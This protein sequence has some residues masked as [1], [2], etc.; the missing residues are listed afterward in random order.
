MGR[1]TLFWMTAA[2]VFLTPAIAF[3]DC[4]SEIQDIDQTIASIEL[5]DGDKEKAMDLRNT[6]EKQCQV[7]NEREAEAVIAQVREILEQ[8]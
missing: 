7:G 4:K 1:E 3:A 2:A 5:S 8:N 6:A